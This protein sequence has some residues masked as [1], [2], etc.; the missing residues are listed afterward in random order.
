MSGL[1]DFVDCRTQRA[2]S[3]IDID[4]L[5]GIDAAIEQNRDLAFAG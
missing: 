4:R 2:F 5:I 3:R 1:G